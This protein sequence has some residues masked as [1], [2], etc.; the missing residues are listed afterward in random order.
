MIVFALAAL[1]QPHPPLDLDT[2]SVARARQLDGERVAVTFL[3]AK[4]AYTLRGV[5][6]AGAAD[7]LDGCERGTVL[8]GKR[9]DADAGQRLTVSGVLRVIDHPGGFVNGGFV[10]GVFVPGWVEVRVEE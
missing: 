4:P 3:V 8:K 2:L 10:N 7:Q 5:T 9:L 6:M 1:L